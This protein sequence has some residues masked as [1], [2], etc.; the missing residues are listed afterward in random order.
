M[1]S[2]LNISFTK[3]YVASL[4]CILFIA[5]TLIGGCGNKSIKEEQY[6]EAVDSIT[7]WYTDDSLT[8]YLEE[9]AMNFYKD[10]KIRVN[11]ECHSGLE[12]IEAVYSQS[13]S[14]KGGPDLYI[15][16]SD[17]IEKAV[18]AG[19]AIPIDNTSQYVNKVNYLD[20][21]VRAVTYKDEVFGYPFYYETAF[22]LYNETYLRE[23]ARSLLMDEIMTEASAGAEDAEEM[24]EVGTVSSDELI[25]EGY[26]Q[27]SWNAAVD[28]KMQELVPGSVE[29][30]LMLADACSAPAGVENIFNWDVNDIFYNYFFTGA[31]INAGGEY[32]DD[33]SLINIYNKDAIQCLYVYQNL[34]QFFSIDSKESSYDKVVQDFIEGKTVFTVVTTDAIAAIETARAEGRFDYE[35]NATMLPGIDAEHEAAGMSITEC[36]MING[37]SVHLES[38]NEFAKFLTDCSGEDLYEK[39]GLM[40]CR[41]V[42]DDY[43]TDVFDIIK[44]SYLASEQLPKLLE[45][46]NYWIGLEYVY[47]SV[48]NG[49]DANETLRLFASDILGQ[50][51]GKPV[52]PEIIEY[53]PPEETEE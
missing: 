43:E 2:R 22:L 16:G 34:N 52:E 45:M 4:L 39:A 3:K 20:T 11:L 18:M 53:T 24:P 48:W 40:S 15:T 35:Y 51:E 17:S 38:A 46:S 42:A 44:E 28:A 32:G 9:K 23:M 13:V 36:L 31:Y 12:F 25:P 37:F 49:A 5:T 26:T 27:E 10:E 14:D 6:S 47:N 21:A 1:P 30:I 50:V 41:N 19:V 7:L 8:P 29:D 33:A